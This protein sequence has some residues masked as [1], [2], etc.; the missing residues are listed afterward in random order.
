MVDTSER[1]VGHLHTARDGFQG[2]NEV[3]DRSIDLC[4]GFVGREEEVPQVGDNRY[5]EYV[6]QY[7]PLGFGERMAEGK[8]AGEP[9]EELFGGLFVYF[10]W[11]DLRAK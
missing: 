1:R 10:K 2:E 6:D 9:G 4:E 11:G 7:H 3:V 8:I 5:D